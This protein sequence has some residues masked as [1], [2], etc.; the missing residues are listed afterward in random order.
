MAL[1]WRPRRHPLPPDGLPARRDAAHRPLPPRG[2]LVTPPSWLRPH[3]RGCR[4]PAGCHRPARRDRRGARPRGA[5]HHHRGPRHP[6]RRRGRRGHRH[7]AGRR[8]RRPTAAARPWTRSRAGSSTSPRRSGWAATV[9]TQLTPGLD[10]RLDV[11]RRARQAARVRHRPARSP[12]RRGGARAGARRA[13]RAAGHLPAVRL[14]R[15]RTR[16]RGSAPPR[17]R[18]CAAATTAASPSTSSRR[19]DDDPAA[20]RPPPSGTGPGSTR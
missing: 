12:R 8:S 10:H 20:P 4:R 3:R 1:P 19:S 15:H 2:D 5:G 11:G 16:S 17:A 7:G 9:A 14:R 13:D 6:A 18:P